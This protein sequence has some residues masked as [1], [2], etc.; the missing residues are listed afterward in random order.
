MRVIKLLGMIISGM[1]ILG[2][3]IF[4]VLIFA[5][6]NN[7]I[8]KDTNTVIET[9]PSPNGKYNAY[10]FIK[11]MGATTGGVVNYL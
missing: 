4:W 9:I 8:M 3:V 2:V 10:I 1:I 11:D 6:F 5:V 7:V